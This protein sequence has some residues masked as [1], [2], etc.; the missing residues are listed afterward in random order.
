MKNFGSI[1]AFLAVSATVVSGRALPVEN[2][3]EAR[4]PYPVGRIST[5]T[6]KPSLMVPQMLQRYMLVNQRRTRLLPVSITTDMDI[7]RG[8][9][10]IAN[11]TASAAAAVAS[12]TEK[13]AKVCHLFAG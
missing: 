4:A 2:G 5:S 1:L 3:L 6:Y 10:Y 9:H 7:F 13:K 12:A 8:L 11:E